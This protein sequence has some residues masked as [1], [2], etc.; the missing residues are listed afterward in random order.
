MPVELMS[1]VVELLQLQKILMPWEIRTTGIASRTN[2]GSASASDG[3]SRIGSSGNVGA[4]ERCCRPATLELK[5]LG[6]TGGSET[7]LLQLEIRSRCAS[8]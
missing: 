2:G 6:G 4:L 3:G 8:D 7:N 5:S 1:D